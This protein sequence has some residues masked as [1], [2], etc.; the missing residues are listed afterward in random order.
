ML[1]VTI[2]GVVVCSSLQYQSLSKV[3]LCQL[4]VL[5]SHESRQTRALLVGNAW[6]RTFGEIMSSCYPYIEADGTSDAR[7]STVE[8]WMRGGDSAVSN[9]RDQ[10]V[11]TRS[12]EPEEVRGAEMKQRRSIKT[13]TGRSAS[14]DDNLQGR[15][16]MIIKAIK[17]CRRLVER[18]CFRSG[19]VVRQK[20]VA[21]RGLI[22]LA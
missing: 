4:V 12:E 17:L 13:D 8:K 15:S 3:E 14:R 11:R 20:T 5:Q 21:E 19:L 9:Q 16:Y 6:P 1:S 2:F 18:F 10:L 22:W 7:I